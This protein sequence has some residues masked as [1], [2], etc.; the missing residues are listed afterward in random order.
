MKQKGHKENATVRTRFFFQSL[1][2][3]CIS[4]ASRFQVIRDQYMLNVVHHKSLLTL[5]IQEAA[6]SDKFVRESGEITRS[7]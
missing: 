2:P 3:F 7:G 4:L 6:F 1:S 5:I